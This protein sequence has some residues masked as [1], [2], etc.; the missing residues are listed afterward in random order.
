M[1][2]INQAI[3]TARRAGL[4]GKEFSLAEADLDRFVVDVAD[5]KYLNDIPNLDYDKQWTIPVKLDRRRK[6]SVLI[7]E[8]GSTLPVP[9]V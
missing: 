7:C 3:L 5:G 6:K 9:K 8:D 4:Y 2:D 1:L